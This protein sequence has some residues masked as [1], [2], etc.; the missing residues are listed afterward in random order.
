MDVGRV[1]FLQGLHDDFLQDEWTE[2]TLRCSD[3][4]LVN[5]VDS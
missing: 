1:Q 4:E 5:M 2:D 3:T